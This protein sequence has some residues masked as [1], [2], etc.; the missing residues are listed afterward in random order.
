MTLDAR[1]SSQFRDRSVNGVPLERIGGNLQF[2]ESVGIVR[3]D[4]DSTRIV[5]IN[6]QLKEML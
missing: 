2:S 3:K 4:R 5:A 1:T 6:D